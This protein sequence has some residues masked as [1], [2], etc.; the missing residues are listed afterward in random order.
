MS[1]LTNRGVNLKKEKIRLST[2]R[3]RDKIVN[4]NSMFFSL[5]LEIRYQDDVH[6]KV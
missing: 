4:L 2:K 1:V 6:Q 3:T 5:E